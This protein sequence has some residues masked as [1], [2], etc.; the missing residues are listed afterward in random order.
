MGGGLLLFYLS[1]ILQIWIEDCGNVLLHCTLD[2]DG[3]W[4]MEK[5]MVQL[6]LQDVPDQRYPPPLFFPF[7]CMRLLFPFSFFP[8]SLLMFSDPY[9]YFIH[10]ALSFFHP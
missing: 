10:H 5:K 1:C 6:S 8:P 7:L 2:R 4:K 9:T 3:N